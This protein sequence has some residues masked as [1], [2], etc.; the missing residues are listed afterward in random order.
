VLCGKLAYP[1]NDRKRIH[2]G[3]LLLGWRLVLHTRIIHVFDVYRK[4]E[5]SWLKPWRLTARPEGTAACGGLK[6]DAVMNACATM[7]Y[8]CV[9]SP[10]LAMRH[11]FARP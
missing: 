1:L 7:T 6:P 5:D 11:A 8:Y 10:R 2:K 3:D 9:T 4:R